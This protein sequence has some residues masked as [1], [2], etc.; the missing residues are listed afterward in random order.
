[1]KK[2]LCLSFALSAFLSPVLAESPT[3]LGR[4]GAWDVFKATEEGKPICYMTSSATK[5]EG[6]YKVRGPAFII[7][8]HRPYLNSYFSVSIDAGYTIHS[9]HKMTLIAQQKSYAFD[10]VQGE[11]AWISQATTDK[12]VALAIAKTSGNIVVKG[13]SSRGTLTT[14][15]YSTRGSLQ[16]LRTMSRACR[17]AIK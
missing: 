17:V 4:F 15:T 11:T 10:L 13:K 1:M 3:R 14:D 2:Y 9:G 6:K 16:A 7:V 12:K 5:A 8:T